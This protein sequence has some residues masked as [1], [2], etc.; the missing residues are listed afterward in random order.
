MKK[1]RFTRAIAL[2][3]TLVMALSLV[4]CGHKPAVTP[5]D[6]AKPAVT[7]TDKAKDNTPV[8]DKKTA[9]AN[10][11]KAKADANKT[12]ADA[13]KA[14]TKT[15]NASKPADSKSDSKSANSNTT[16]P[17][18][19]PASSNQSTA[20]PSSGNTGSSTKTEPKTPTQPSQP[21]QPTKPAEP[22]K[23]A[24]SH[25]YT[26]KVVAPTCTEKGYTVHTCSCGDSYKDNYKNK[27]GHYYI[28]KSVRPTASAKGYDQFTCTVCGYS[29]KDNYVDPV[30]DPD[31]IVST[32]AL[33]RLCA[34][35]TAYAK[36]IGLKIDD[37]REGWGAGEPV[38]I[39]ES[40]YSDTLIDL[41]CVID[42]RLA[43][44]GN[45]S[46]VSVWYQSGGCFG[47]DYE[48]C[49]SGA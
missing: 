35:A 45:G 1:N 40:S 48:I 15:D 37:G 30:T 11:D 24:H 33:D 17:A 36:S 3:M 27:T 5:D 34:E 8:A 20:K 32:A 19:K 23:P 18:Q 9:D 29:Y 38:W 13:D 49:I 46:Y 42:H 31:I 43:D 26:T 7:E 10:A 28:V 6:T 47:A 25:S 41:K 16:A 2:V 14:E 22:S 12:T 39:G 4:A 44:N 21:S